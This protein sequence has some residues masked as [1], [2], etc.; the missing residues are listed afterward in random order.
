MRYAMNKNK[1]YLVDR[2][3]M[4]LHVRYVRRGADHCA[5]CRLTIGQKDNC[6]MNK[7][8]TNA[9]RFVCKSFPLSRVLLRCTIDFLPPALFAGLGKGSEDRC[10]SNRAQGKTKG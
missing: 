4:V 7:Q 5:A 9:R 8:I 3:V 6:K 10:G 2:Y 1:G